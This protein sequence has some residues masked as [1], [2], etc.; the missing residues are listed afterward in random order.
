MVY[1]LR[2][3]SIESAGAARPAHSGCGGLRRR[4]GVVYQERDLGREAQGEEGRQC[5][6]HLAGRL[7]RLSEFSAR[8]R[9]ATP[10]FIVSSPVGW[11]SIEWNRGHHPEPP[12]ERRSRSARECTASID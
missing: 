11:L 5:P 8:S 3:A 2:Y 7:G 6:G 1:I 12:A 10:G 4:D 9:A